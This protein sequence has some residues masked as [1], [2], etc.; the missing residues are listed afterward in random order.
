[1]FDGKLSYSFQISCSAHHLWDSGR[2]DNDHFGFSH[3]GPE[4]HIKAEVFLHQRQRTGLHRQINHGLVNCKAWVGINYFIS[5]INAQNAVKDNGLH[6]LQ[7][8]ARFTEMF[9]S[10][11]YLARSQA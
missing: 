8:H 7:L 6:Q 11:M 3:K 1:M 2:V 5:W 4:L 10:D 9:S